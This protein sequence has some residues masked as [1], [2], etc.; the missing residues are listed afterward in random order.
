[1]GIQ[2]RKY[3][4]KHKANHTLKYAEHVNK[5]SQS[6]YYES[7]AHLFLKVTKSW[8]Y[9]LRTKYHAIFTFIWYVSVFQLV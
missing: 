9:H 1:M 8:K 2:L 7:N 6:L 4:N 3:L 5:Q